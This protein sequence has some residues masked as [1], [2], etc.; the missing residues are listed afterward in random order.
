MFNRQE[1]KSLSP[2]LGPLSSAGIF[3]VWFLFE[4][5]AV[6]NRDTNF[7]NSVGNDGY[8]YEPKSII[9]KI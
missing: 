3:A 5:F 6:S 7:K 9:A 4:T 2:I 8:A 1:D